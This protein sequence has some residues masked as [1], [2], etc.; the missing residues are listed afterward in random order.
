[1]FSQALAS[2]SSFLGKPLTPQDL[3]NWSFHQDL[4]ID[5]A[6]GCGFVAGQPRPEGISGFTFL[7]VYQGVTYDYRVSADSQI[8]FPCIPEGGGQIP[9]QAP[10]PTNS[11]TNCP[12]D[13]AGYLP[14]KLQIG[15]QGRIGTGGTPN[16]L[17]ALPSVNGEQIG[18]IQPG[19]IVTILDGPSCEEASHLVFWRVNDQ[20]TI[21]WT[22]EGTPP[23]SYF[24]DAVGGTLPAERSL[25][26]AANA[27][28]LASLGKIPM[29]GVTSISFTQDSQRMALGGQGGVAVYDLATLEENPTPGDVAQ[30]VTAV[31]FSPDGRY[32]AYSQQNGNLMVYDM[33]GNTRTTLA[34]LVNSQINALAFSPDQRYLLGVGTGMEVNLPGTASVW[35][36]YNLAANSAPAMQVT[37]SWVRNVAFSLDGSLFAWLDTSLHINQVADNASI[38]T[39]AIQQAPKGGL[40]W[41]PA[42][43]GTLPAHSVAFVD[44]NRIRLDNLDTSVEQS[45]T[46]DTS[47][48]PGVI[49]FNLDGSLL[50]AMDVPTNTVTGS[51]V[52]IF[53][54][55]SAALVSS[56]ALQASNTLLFSPDGTLLVIASNDIVQ[57]MGVQDESEEAV[58]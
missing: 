16:R 11:A 52:N 39:L 44:G 43:V 4:Y 25:I 7:M 53:D 24:L 14:P 10:Q 17:R 18:L 34:A 35:Q 28:T 40:V 3:D 21:G 1:Q 57:V 46:G 37:D 42:P 20:G 8:I 27:A 31:A 41:R 36:I 22:A 23:S 48:L 30:P 50:A 51:V 5:T 55:N 26:S 15:G 54:A 29:A 12:A 47:F 38:R 49:S 6:L 32:L 58:G 13:F 33:I 19:E 9:T 45:F 2:L 56:T